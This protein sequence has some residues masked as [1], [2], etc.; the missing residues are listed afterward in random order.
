VQANI[1]VGAKHDR[2]KYEII[3]NNLYAVMLRP[4]PNP[5]AP[6]NIYVALPDICGLPAFKEACHQSLN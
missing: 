2:T 3:S 6:K 1:C 4:L 5:D